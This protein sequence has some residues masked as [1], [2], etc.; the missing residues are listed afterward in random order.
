MAA[1]KVSVIVPV[2]NVEKYLE[3][4]LNSILSQTFNDFEC[5]LVDDASPDNCPELCD[6]YAKID[7]RIKIIHNNINIGSS[8]SR[9]VGFDLAGGDYILFVDSDDWIEKDMLEKMYNA[10]VSYGFDIVCCD[11]YRN[12]DDS[13]TYEKQDL[14]CID[15]FN[16]LGFVN[17]CAVW[18][19]LFLKEILLKVS[20]PTYGKYEDRVITQQALYYAKKP[21]KIAYPLY[22]YN[23]NQESIT[24]NTANNYQ[25]LFEWQQNIILVI[26]FLK[27]KLKDDFIKKSDNINCYVN[28]FKL[29]VS[30]D[31]GIDEDKKKLLC[32]FYPESK[33]K[34]ASLPPQS[35]KYLLKRRF[36]KIVVLFTPPII[37]VVLK[38]LLKN[39]L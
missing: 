22:H 32:D 4:C 15:N 21:G 16:N 3:K 9:K 24:N 14:D 12:K 26:K 19:K 31:K 18:N 25:T 17:C 13:Y 27:E 8:L 2:Y 1:V 23:F 30:L 28:N 39:R 20:F 37:I 35:Y 33:F 7:N 36:K 10:A 29:Q 38:K 34:E 5:I 11:F 6:E